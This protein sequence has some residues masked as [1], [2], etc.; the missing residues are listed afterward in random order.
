M[1]LPKII[2]I[3]LKILAVLL[4]LMIL[5]LIIFQTSWFKNYAAQKA[6]SYL[7][8]ELG[9]DVS[10]GKI[11]LSYFDRLDAKDI[12][13]ADQN[14]DTMIYVSN[15]EV[16]YDL[17]SFSNESI[18]FDDVLIDKGVINIGIKKDSSS[19]NIQHL[20]DY[21]TPPSTGKKGTAQII[22][23]DKVE[24]KNTS[25]NYFNK[26]STPPQDRAFDENDMVF[27]QL[28]GHLHDFQ[29]INDSMSFVLDD[30]S[31][32][33]KSGLQIDDL[34]AITTISSTTMRFDDLRIITPKSDIKDY[35][36][37][38]YKSYADFSDFIKVVKVK[39]NFDRS[40]IHT[41][42]LALFSN[43]LGAYKEILTA[44]GKVDGT[45]ANLRSR[46]LNLSI[47][48]HTNFRGSARLEGLPD[49]YKT[50]FDINAKS[51]TTNTKDL[52]KLIELNPIPQE[53]L[54]LG[55]VKYI[56]TFNGYID[57][58]KINADI[59]SD[60]GPLKTTF[61]FNQQNTIATYQGTVQSDNFNL[62]RLLG[63]QKL[64]SS[65]FNLDIDGR[66]LSL[67]ELSAG[68]TGQVNHINYDGYDYKNIGIN[69]NVKDKIFAG[70][71][72]INDPNFNL[73]FDGN[74]DV[75]ADQPRI[76][77]STNVKSLNLKTLGLDSLD[78]IVS[79]NGDIKLKGD[80]IDNISGNINLD[81]F[82]LARNKSVYTLKN[83]ILNATDSNGQKHYNLRSNLLDADIKG[84]FLPSEIQDIVAYVEHIISPN[85]YPN[86]E[87][88][89][90]SKDLTI[91][92][93][94]DTFQPLFKEFLGDAFFD[95]ADIFFGY[96]HTNGKITGKSNI[97]NFRYDIVSTPKLEITLNNGGNLTP[98]N[99]A[100]N[101]AGLLQN[102]STI[103][104]RLNANGYIKDGIVNFE[105]TAQRD[106]ILDLAIG[107]RFLYQND[108]VLVYVDN[109]KVLIYDESWDLRKSNT[110]NLIYQNGIT[111]LRSFDFRNNEQILY[112]EA[113]SG[114]LADKVNVN[115]TD[116]KLENLTPF[117]AGFDIKLQGITNGYIDVS[118]RD[119]FPIIEADL[120]IDD[121]QLDDDT[122]GTLVLNSVNKDGLLAVAID[123]S[124]VGGLLNDMKILG[125][126]DFKDKV[127]P[128][129]LALSTLH[130]SIKPFEKY[131]DGLAS[132]LSGYST[133]DIKI[134]GPLN[135][136]KLKGTMAIDSLNF[137]I[138]YLQT[139]YS[140]QANIDIDYNSFTLTNANLYDRFG[141]KGTVKGE[142]S[143]TNF[144]DF[145][146]NINIS[147]LE[148]FEI[149]NTQREDN[150]LFYGTAFV[151]GNM[152]VLGPMDD[153]LL[154][155]NAKSRK[156][157]KILIPLDN[158]ETSGKLSYVE[159]VDLKA[160]NNNL[161]NAFKA[162]AG[163]RM[164][165]NFEITNDASITLV[166]DE[167]LGDKIEA[168]GH[169]NLRMEIN[170]YGDFSMYGGLT[171]DKGSYLFTALDL[172]TKYFTVKQGGTLFWDG[173][174]Y[175]AKI[176]LEA[177]TREYP[178]PLSLV[179]GTVPASEESLY[180]TAIPT[181]C[182]LKLSG[183]LFNPEVS[184]DLS[185]PSK[186]VLSGSA[187]SSLNTVLDRV[188]LDQEE[189][190]R[191]VFALLVLGTFVP[192][193][194][195]TGSAE[196]AFAVG[197]AN[198]GINSLSDFA[199]SQL[200]NWLGQ[201]D[202]RLQLGVDYQTSYESSAELIVSLKRK[203][204][205]DR[206][207]VSG[208][209]DA[210]AQG[211]KP[212]D[213]S[214][215]YNIAEDGNT[216]IRGFQKLANDPTLGNINNVTTTGVGLFYRFQFD[217]FRLRKKKIKP[218]N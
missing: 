171:I 18:Q 174:P 6:T 9:V 21:F 68:L 52:A 145:R 87:N 7:S 186:T 160:D 143:H 124:I 149:M 27:T 81:S 194:F 107:G 98:V 161:N 76:A 113:S 155:I 189:L 208:S 95:S 204:L 10:I 135:R 102:D 42:D 175:N 201:L 167:L 166:F 73:D 69:G 139:N 90:V 108:S 101:T 110:P 63:D 151:D 51:L 179:K 202:T 126:I 187:N 32:K 170:T 109:S 33:E 71:F 122:L 96:N 97:K 40:H 148:N 218:E 154:Q 152:K 41:D 153:I 195:A 203:F 54:N 44:T 22:T 61:S 183:L 136:P 34:G 106:S 72:K 47:G 62:Q 60:V 66:G 217:K 1:A 100:I 128:L 190:N 38:N 196:N 17:F 91:D 55:K 120:I 3:P 184:F 205:N 117:I 8:E 163:V 50:K 181:D 11:S 169:G 53:F 178:V 25:F 207:E 56:G 177:I 176:N 185:F 209:V 45:I 140:G 142:V 112:L 132:N 118:D 105:T 65:S 48:N 36:E 29:I 37:F 35:L 125:D 15:L 114:Y 138:D 144:Q 123:G 75:T 57:D 67:K 14:A 19:L 92:I 133:T 137:V 213:I 16:N 94:I 168:S 13:I 159:F 64:G 156:G 127:S 199:S 172:I 86:P 115:L 131:L 162:A 119:G 193:S 146:F 83:V 46:D 99:F 30:I 215:E 70:N 20:I 214:V 26:N 5:I 84:E 58:F 130:S 206:L 82:I 141:Q 157:T 216:K 88:E 85:Q 192:P 198:T 210:A 80:N 93:D 150:E 158:S 28:N 173:N 74:L 31:G 165:F 116:F 147:D 4:G 180:E 39:S 2:K 78:N 212:Y 191:Q 104:N 103:F 121:L 211:S 182:Y 111:E 197:A 77:I 200:N 59:N 188:R 24:I 164:D 43:T 134:T 129:N 12:Y 79:F 49:I 89:L 23:F